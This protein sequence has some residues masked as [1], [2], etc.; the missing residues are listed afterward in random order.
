MK[1]IEIIG[2]TIERSLSRMSCAHSRYDI[3]DSILDDV[4]SN[5]I[6]SNYLVRD[7]GEI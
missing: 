4:L 7:L 1:S 5:I 6:H 3:R 2:Y